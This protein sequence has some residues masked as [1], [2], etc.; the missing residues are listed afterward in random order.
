M[1][2][3]LKMETALAAMTGL[4]QAQNSIARTLVALPSRDPEASEI[5]SVAERLAAIRA[6]LE[7]RMP[8]AKQG[9]LFA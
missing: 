1:S 6:R 9:G 7:T 8:K 3:A 2:A 4:E 5:M